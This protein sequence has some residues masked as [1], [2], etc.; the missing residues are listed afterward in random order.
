VNDVI[1]TI[2]RNG[3]TVASFDP[4]VAHHAVA[5]NL[6]GDMEQVFAEFKRIA[7]ATDCAVEIVHPTR[8]PSSGQEELSAVDSRGSSTIIYAARSALILN[9][10]PR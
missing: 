10:R 7:Y 6:T 5:E 9:I 8:K 2:L 3:I 4:L 1:S